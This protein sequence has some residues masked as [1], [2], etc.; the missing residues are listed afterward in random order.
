M[1][2]K[3]VE[4]FVPVLF[5]PV[6]AALLGCSEVALEGPPGPEGPAGP[7]G[8]QG[9]Q[10][11]RGELGAEGPEGPPFVP[12]VYVVRVSDE[13]GN[14]AKTAAA[15]G[16]GDV[17]TGGGCDWGDGIAGDSIPIIDPLDEETPRGW[18]CVASSPGFVE[19]F[20]VC[21]EVEP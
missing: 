3:G 1:T 16:A 17:A 6:L 7:R 9:A 8:E 19:T 21:M 4:L 12:V 18:W 10:G 20:A 5:V 11:E 13:L 15:C 2:K 14:P